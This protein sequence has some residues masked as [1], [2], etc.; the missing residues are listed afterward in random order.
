MLKIETHV[1]NAFQVNTYLIINEQG[2]CLVIDPAFYSPEEIRTFDHYV[3]S[4]ELRIIGQVNTHCH[5]DHVL[6]V[7]HMQTRYKCP[8]RAHQDEA[9]LLNN[10]PLMGEIYGLQL[11]PLSGIDQAIQEGELIFIGQ[12]SLQS[13]LVPGHSP[14][15]LS[16]YSPDAGFVLTGDALFQ[17][18]IGR[19]DLPGGDYDTLI[20]SIKNKLLSLPGETRVFPGHGDPSTIGEEALNNPFLSMA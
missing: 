4:K 11:E 20:S 2:D 13:I 5:V 18:S 10:A 19:T 15:S 14:G 7:R 9:N 1:F 16:F 17:G 6:G 3:A 8:L 12:D